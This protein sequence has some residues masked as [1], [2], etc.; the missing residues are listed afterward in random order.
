MSKLA[1]ESHGADRF[2]VY[3]D[4]K[5][6]GA[7]WD[8]GGGWLAETVNGTKVLPVVGLSRWL[9]QGGAGLALLC[10]VLDVQGRI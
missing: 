4:G 1:Y 6:I 9:S 8:D 5:L 2:A 7:A 3:Y 10:F